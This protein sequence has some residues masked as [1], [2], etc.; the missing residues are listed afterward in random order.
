MR[1]NVDAREPRRL[2]FLLSFGMVNVADLL[3]AP[4][5]LKAGGEIT[6]CLSHH[7]CCFESST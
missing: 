2:Q 3:D 4:L 5:C 7:M 1:R 6:E